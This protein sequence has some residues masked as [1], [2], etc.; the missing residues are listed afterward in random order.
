MEN[1]LVIGNGFDI[2]HG[3]NTRYS[4]FINFCN[5]VAVAYQNNKNQFVEQLELE[6]NCVFKEKSVLQKAKKYFMQSDENSNSHKFMELC[7]ENYWLD[8]VNVNK[9]FIGE[10]WSDFEYVIAEQIEM[11]SYISNHFDLYTSGTELVRTKYSNKLVILFDEIR[12]HGQSSSSDFHYL[13]EQFKKFLVDE[14]DNLTWMLEIYLTRFL[15]TKTKTLELFETLPVTK[16]ISF[17]YTETFFKMY[18]QK[19]VKAHYIHG[20]ALKDRATE[21]NNMVFGIGTEIKNTSDD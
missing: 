2:A 21:N 18:H 20:T 8:Y 13:I 9:E 7:L 4:D 16:L 10:K 1:I 3:L 6:L 14:L 15:N 17:N 12:E 19:T 11:L 5:A